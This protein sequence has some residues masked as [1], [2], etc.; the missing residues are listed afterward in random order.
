MLIWVLAASM[1]IASLGAAAVVSKLGFGGSELG[2]KLIHISGAFGAIFLAFIL[3]L[4]EVAILMALMSVVIGLSHVFHWPEQLYTE[5]RR[6]YGDILL[7]VGA[8]VAA[9]L[10]PSLSAFVCAMVVV[11][12]GD[13][14]AGLVGRR[15]AAR[16]IWPRYNAKTYLGST[17]F[18]IVAALA[19]TALLPIAWYVALVLASL[20]AVIE[21]LSPLG[22]DNL[23][24]PLA[25]SLAAQYLLV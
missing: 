17:I 22:S 18:F 6:S 10:S 3:P 23:L 19:C 16:P 24:L 25:V 14:L 8:L 7:P 12:L 13:G 5:D 1:V 21:Y 4:D 11:G 2:R 9:L 15:F 20:L